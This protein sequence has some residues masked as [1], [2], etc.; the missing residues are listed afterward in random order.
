MIVVDSSALIDSFMD[1]EH[2]RVFSELM[3]T[4]S[5]AAP[6][7]IY[8]ETMHSL[9]KLE[10]EDAISTIFGE[11]CVALLGN[12]PINRYATHDMLWESWSLR[13]N[14]TAYD[15]PYV[16]LAGILDATLLTH[17]RR[18]AKAAQFQVKTMRLD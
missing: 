9:R 5:L 17:D 14:I 3:K 2:A 4:E 13:H 7:H 16:I 10:R 1:I 6:S 11:Q 15:A 18:L 8:V 12:L